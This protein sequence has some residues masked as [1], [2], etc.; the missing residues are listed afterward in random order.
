MDG[1]NLLTAWGI[2]GH[3]QFI[4]LVMSPEILSRVV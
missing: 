3:W 1:G 4:Y 2:D